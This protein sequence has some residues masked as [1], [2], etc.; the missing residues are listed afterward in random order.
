M[1][2]KN[3]FVESGGTF[4]MKNRKNRHDIYRDNMFDN[5][6]TLYDDDTFDPVD[7]I[8][9][10]ENTYEIKSTAKKEKP[11]V[12]NSYNNDNY[13]MYGLNE[14][15]YSYKPD[16]YEDV[17]T[18]VVKDYDEKDKLSF[19][20]ME[21]NSELLSELPLDPDEEGIGFG[22]HADQPWKKQPVKKKS[23]HIVLWIVLVIFV[24]ALG[25]GAYFGIDYLST[26]NDS[27]KGPVNPSK[28][29]F[30]F[31][32]GN[33]FNVVPNGWDTGYS[34]AV[35][36][37]QPD[38]EYS[39]YVKTS[40]DGSV[41]FFADNANAAK[42]EAYNLY[43]RE[44][45]QKLED[46]A[47]AQDD[48]HRVAKDVSGEFEVSNNGKYVAYLKNVE[49]GK[50]KL[51]I[52]DLK[53][54]TVIEERD[55]VSFQF[56]DDNNYILYN[57]NSGEQ[58]DT[59]YIKRLGDNSEKQL[60]DNNVVKIVSC[61]PDFERIYYL[62]QS[63]YSEEQTLE[64]QNTANSNNEGSGNT[65]GNNIQS[66]S[67]SASGSISQPDQSSQS[68]QNSSSSSDTEFI[69]IEGSSS[70]DTPYPEDGPA[71]GWANPGITIKQSFNSPIRYSAAG[72]QTLTQNNGSQSSS[73]SSSVADAP[74]DDEGGYAGMYDPSASQGYN[75]NMNGSNG[76][77]D[78]Y[79][80]NDIY[81]DI[82]G[83]NQSNNM[84]NIQITD[85]EDSMWEDVYCSL[86]LKVRDR[87]PIQIVDGVVNV[88]DVSEKGNFV[89]AMQSRTQLTYDD[90]VEDSYEASDMVIHEP[91]QAEYYVTTQVPTDSS[92]TQTN[93]VRT[94][95]SDS[96]NRAMQA[97]NEKRQRDLV[98]Q[99]L[100][101]QVVT[102]YNTRLYSF[103][104]GTITKITDDCDSYYP[105]DID[106]GLVAFTQRQ[107]EAIKRYNITDLIG[108]TS[109]VLNQTGKSNDITFYLSN[110][111]D[112][113]ELSRSF[114]ADSITIK[115][116][117]L[118]Y[119]TEYDSQA[120]KGILMQADALLSPVKIADDVSEY[121]MDDMGNNITY[122][123]NPDNGYGQLNV[124]SGNS[125]LILSES[126]KLGTLKASSDGSIAVVEGE[127][128][129]LIYWNGK[130]KTELAANASQV[131]FR[132]NKNIL[133][134]AD[135]NGENNTLYYY[136][137]KNNQKLIEGV[138]F[139]V[140]PFEE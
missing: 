110:G 31:V 67:S 2:G 30:M 128:N 80:S 82:F 123:V 34:A 106:S 107:P 104:D 46:G 61:T 32:S 17:I 55:V 47:S 60:I 51:Y 39:K 11:Q 77:N 29:P 10:D 14:D 27:L 131:V 16:K 95:D 65:S 35:F 57:K 86:N 115:N 58:Y 125:R 98:R 74:I 103:V 85:T 138:N 116:N 71:V 121:V 88:S 4:N 21:N 112:Q 113:I 96:Y 119:I 140:W 79:P 62:R 63:D 73:S 100:S 6:E 84:D 118:F 133:Y 3:E 127:N 68:A 40:N 41:I 102:I 22:E 105:I 49:N 53:L 20:I 9:Y 44:T 52:S 126:A 137:G 136:N 38:S 70:S 13:N 24:L 108:N 5:K 25:T 111:S 134:L 59:V 135:N 42:G 83:G 45:E 43:Y 75:D 76:Y 124:K 7:D 101:S 12:K 91:N 122:I 81:D 139:I 117:K 92:G 66:P 87:D 23:K 33:Q 94:F 8:M 114:N 48:A 56:S 72:N 36:N 50:G 18:S 129:N 120:D 54:E 93:E 89:F 1:D 37:S 78:S 90:L 28:F 15:D 97:Y 69:P 130:E 109:L 64:E 132:D 19:K 99:E 26:K